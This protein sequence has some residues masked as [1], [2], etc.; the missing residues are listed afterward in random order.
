MGRKSKRFINR[1]LSWLEF[2]QRVLDEAQNEANP[3]LERL[4]FVAI[5]ASNLDEFF[6]VRVGSIN[7]M[8]QQ[9]VT[10]PELSGLTPVEQM[11]AISE[12]C[13]KMVQDQYDI[14][15]NHLE[16]ALKQEGIVRQHR[17]ELTEKQYQ[18]LQNVIEEEV[19][20]I[21]TPMVVQLDEEFP[22]LINQSLNVCA[23]VENS[24]GE[25]RFVV[26]PFARTNLRFITLPSESGYQYILL[27]DALALFMPLLFPGENVIETVPFRITRNADFQLREDSASDLMAG[28]KEVLDARKEGTCIRLETSEFI[29][30]DML[31]FLCEGLG[32]DRQGVYVVP[33][34]VDLAAYFRM[35]GLGGYDHLKY[36]DWPPLREASLDPR[37]TMFQEIA[38]RDILL[39]HP[40]ESYDPVVRFLEEAAADPDVLAIKQ[41]L[42]RTSSQSAIV[43]AL[44]E[45]A[46]RGKHVTALVELKA[47]FDE[48]RNIKWAGELEQVGI[49]VIYGVKGLKTHA[50]ICLVVRRE[51]SGI[52]R[53]M[54]FGTGNYNESTAKLYSDISFMTCNPELGADASNFFNAISGYSQPMKFSKV[55]VA[56]IGLREKI[57]ELINV[58]TDRKKHGQKARITIKMNSLVDSEIIEALYQASQAGVKVRLNIRGICC[59]KPGVKGLS[60]NITV[61]SIIDRFLEHSRILHFLHGGDDRVYISSADWMPRNLDRRVELLVP[62]DDKEC[63]SKLINTLNT[64][65]KDNVKSRKL[66]AN[67]TFKLVDAGS[68][69]PLRVQEY[70]YEQARNELEEAERTHQMVFEPHLANDN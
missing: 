63:K 56:P 8:V 14:L 41:T 19:F 28:M 33:G 20:S 9:E 43:A 18:V 39:S 55:E 32:I 4:K 60:E 49:Q 3:L 61:I 47:R 27:E 30:S 12:R 22:L 52:R 58:E 69:K 38:D 65:F 64:Y 50:K 13:Q 31:A 68:R 53:Y 16:P 59:L 51:P 67:E 7:M 57:L 36:P 44:K 17:Q 35:A 26:I 24:E 15:L 46:E 45:A 66:L 25:R 1:E 37:K 11:A 10:T 70:L 5:T 40:Y 29:T 34:P 2:N 23:Q 62:I 54:H 42:Y 6:M 21:L 48:A